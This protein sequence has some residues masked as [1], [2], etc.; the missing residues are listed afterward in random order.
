MEIGHLFG[1]CSDFQL[2][3]ILESK[4]WYLQHFAAKSLFEIILK[5]VDRGF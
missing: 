3:R 5:K 2:Q 1:I 4:F